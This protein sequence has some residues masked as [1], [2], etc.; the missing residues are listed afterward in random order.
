MDEV[1]DLVKSHIG[2]RRPAYTKPEEPGSERKRS[3]SS[4]RPEKVKILLQK[5][6]S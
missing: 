5:R 2:L 4:K 3:Q 6:I 1:H